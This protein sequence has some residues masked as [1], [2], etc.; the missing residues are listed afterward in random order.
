MRRLTLSNPTIAAGARSIVGVAP[1][2]RLVAPA[3]SLS[4]AEQMQ[5]NTNIA[6]EMTKKFKGEVPAP[7][8]RRHNMNFA[9]I[10]KEVEALLGASKSKGGVNPDK[11]MERMGVI[12]SCLRQGVWNYLKDEGNTNYAE[13]K[14][15]IA[16]TGNDDSRLAEAQRDADVAEKVAALKKK[17]A[18]AGQSTVVLP[19]VNWNEE[20]SAVIDREVVAEKRFRYD[21]LSVNTS[22]RDEKAIADLQSQYRQSVQAKRL[23]NIVDMIAKFKPIIAREAI[24]QRLTIKHLEGQLGTWR[25]L[26]WNPEVRDRAETEIDNGC[27]W[28]WYELEE[29]RMAT[30]RL[31]SRT[32]VS[33]IMEKTQSASQAKKQTKSVASGA[34]SS[35]KNEARQRLLKEVIML[36]QRR[37][38]A[39][40]EAA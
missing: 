38:Q 12:E 6:L 25:Y 9:D 18:E 3:P 33:Q 17:K 7:Y 23:D 28:W 13:M 19:E 4:P 22:A 1:V 31:R 26:D 37:G 35:K 24:M 32:E 14:K 36:Q 40:D 20:Y 2:L 15:W 27:W 16:Y 5:R 30:I 8:E 21:V 10:E 11:P 34:G 29:K 39:A